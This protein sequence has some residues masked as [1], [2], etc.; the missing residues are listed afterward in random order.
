MTQENDHWQMDRKVPISILLTIAAQG[1]AGVWYIADIKKDVEIL[2]M[3][4][5]VQLGRDEQQ[6]KATMQH[7]EAVTSWLERVD[8][9]L[10]RLLIERR[11]K[12]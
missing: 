6:D 11:G 9:K 5:H 12:P 4:S 2:K 8:G 3:Q 10:D 1:I 7:I